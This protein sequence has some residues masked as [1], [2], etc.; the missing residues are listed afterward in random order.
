MERFKNRDIKKYLIAL[1]IFLAAGSAYAG[2]IATFADPTSDGSTPLFTINLNTDKI[3]AGWAD[4]QT[5]LTL[6]VLGTTYNDAYFTMTDVTYTGGITGGTTGGGTI[7][8]F[9]DGGAVPLVQIAFTS[10]HVSP[11][12]F[13]GADGSLFFADGITITGS[14]IAGTLSDESFSFNFANQQALGGNIANGFTATSGFS[15]SAVPEPTSVLLL[16][17]SGLFIR[18]RRRSN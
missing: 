7:S 13:G 1:L 18:R 5:G 6:N 8:L 4:S 9:A 12:G 3:S 14:A 17:I 2:T 15:L 16:G 11:Y 10:A